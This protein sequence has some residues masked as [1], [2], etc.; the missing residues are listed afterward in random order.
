MNVNNRVEVSDDLKFLAWG[1]LRQTKRFNAYNINGFKICTLD[2]EEG[3]KTQNSGIFVIVE[4]GYYGKL[5][6]IIELNYHGQF[7][8][9]LFKCKWVNTNRGV[10]KYSLQFTSVNFS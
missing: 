6:D 5:V 7:T 3:L 9:V 10:R 2:Q 4:L 1:S 8:I